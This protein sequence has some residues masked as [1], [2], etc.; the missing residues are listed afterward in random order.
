MRL[1]LI[2][3]WFLFMVLYLIQF[4]ITGDLWSLFFSIMFLLFFI[5]DLVDGR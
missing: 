5:S 3:S 2:A 4:F 1:F